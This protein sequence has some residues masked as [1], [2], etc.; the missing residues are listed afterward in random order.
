MRISFHKEDEQKE[1]DQ[2]SIASQKLRRTNSFKKSHDAPLAATLANSG[3]VSRTKLE[4]PTPRLH[5]I[6][7]YKAFLKGVGVSGHMLKPPVAG[8]NPPL[9]PPH[10]EGN[11]WGWGGEGA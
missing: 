11:L 4:T 3:S 10:L 7:G 2:K 6:S 1:L 8:V 5:L 9:H